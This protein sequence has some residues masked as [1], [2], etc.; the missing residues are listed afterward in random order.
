MQAPQVELEAESWAGLA[1]V[2]AWRVSTETPSRRVNP[3][4]IDDEDFELA[5]AGLPR[6]DPEPPARLAELEAVE[7]PSLWLL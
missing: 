6:V 4:D 7:V 2:T 3:F 5:L 1:L